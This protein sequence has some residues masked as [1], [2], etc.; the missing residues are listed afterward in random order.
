ME[1][2]TAAGRPVLDREKTAPFL[3]RTFI[4]VGGFHRALQFEDGP[5]P[6][7]DEQQIYTWK[8]A[9]LREVLTTLRP[10]LPST[11]PLARYSFRTLFFDALARGRVST[12][13]LGLIYSRD[14]LGEPGT[15]AAPAPRL[16]TDDEPPPPAAERTLDELRFVP[17][18]FLCVAVLLPKSATVP[19]PGGELAI[20]GG[21]AAAAPGAGAGTNGWKRDAGWSAGAAGGGPPA[22]VGRGGGHWRGDS[23]PVPPAPRSVRAGGRGA[24]LARDRDRDRDADRRAPPLRRDSPPPPRRDW[25]IDRD[26]DRPRDRRVSRS[27][28]PPRRRGSSRY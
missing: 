20:K 21:A 11:H 14:I 27:R 2:T 4:K 9:T 3:I 24:D 28:S 17:G 7:A 16:Q 18:D 10:L 1:E 8:D 6:I 25:N 13:D 26:R 12:K 15:L 19:G 23:N 22:G 5:L